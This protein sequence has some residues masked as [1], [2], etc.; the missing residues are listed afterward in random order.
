MLRTLRKELVDAIPD[1][2]SGVTVNWATLEKLPYLVS[3]FLH[4]QLGERILRILTHYSK[5]AVVKESL[6]FSFGVP[7]RLS[8]VVPAHGAVFCGRQI[9]PGVCRLNPG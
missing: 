7:G 4:Y 9:P 6:R 5:R 2:D 1:L 8:R 3:L